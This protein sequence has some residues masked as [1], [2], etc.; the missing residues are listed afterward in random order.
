[1]PEVIRQPPLTANSRSTGKKFPS[2]YH[3]SNLENSLQE[4]QGDG[5]SPFQEGTEFS[6]ADDQFETGLRLIRQAY[7]QKLCEKKNEI[8]SLKSLVSE[9]EEKI[10][11][12]ERLLSSSESERLRAISQ[13]KKLANDLS[14]L[15]AFK[16]AIISVFDESELAK[17]AT[18]RVQHRYS[19][20]PSKSPSLANRLVFSRDDGHPVFGDSG[21]SHTF[22]AP[23]D[24]GN[25]L[26][27]TVDEEEEEKAREDLD[28][29]QKGQDY[30]ADD[31]IRQMDSFGM[32]KHQTP[33]TALS[34]PLVHSGSPL[35]V[36]DD[37][38]VG[39]EI[40]NGAAAFSTPAKPSR[41]AASAN[42]SPGMTDSNITGKDFFRLARSRL[43]YETFSKFVDIVKEHNM[44]SLS[45][46]DTL[47]Q[48]KLVL[49]TSNSDLYMKFQELLGTQL[50]FASPSS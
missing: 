7:R 45:K 50:S 29:E 10:K 13:S 31:I 23:V 44:N 3:G 14:K 47:S 26:K 19:S 20:T 18:K 34:P 42:P 37:E 5:I 39:E 12:L 36:D 25:L 15:S 49:G 2:H 4:L 35:E 27:F 48:V 32:M 1:M 40:R 16:Q 43:S 22:K 28:G 33:R 6:S 17:E 24:K 11:E 9:K 38:D 30:T 46:S 8:T 41:K 21:S